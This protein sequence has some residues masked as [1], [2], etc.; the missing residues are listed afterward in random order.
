[1]QVRSQQHWIVDEEG[2]RP[3]FQKMSKHVLLAKRGREA[4]LEEK[5]AKYG[6]APRAVAPFRGNRESEVEEAGSLAHE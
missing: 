3:A 1:M 2:R 5:F 6:R 4:S